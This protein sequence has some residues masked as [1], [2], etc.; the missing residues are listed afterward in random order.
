MHVGDGVDGTLTT[1]L[2]VVTTGPVG[3]H[4][5]ETGGAGGLGQ[6]VTGYRLLPGGDPRAGY[7]VFE[8]GAVFASTDYGAVTLSRELA[9]A[10]EQSATRELAGGTAQ[11]LL[12]VPVEPAPPGSTVAT[13][14]RG[15]LVRVPPAAGR[16]AVGAFTVVGD[17][18]DCYVR[19]GVTATLGLPV[20]DQQSRPD[21]G[22]RQRFEHGEICWRSDL[23][24]FAVRNP[25]AAWW[26]PAGPDGPLGYP[27]RDVVPF[28]RVYETVTVHWFRGSFERGDLY[29]ARDGESARVV[30]GEIRTR[31]RTGSAGRRASSGCRSTTRG[32]PR[33]PA[34][35]TRTSRT[36]CWSG[37]RRAT[38]M[39]APGCSARPSSA[40]RRS[41]WS[42]RATARSAATS[43]SSSARWS[44]A[45][46]PRPAPGSTSS[47]S[48]SPRTTTG[49]TPATTPSPRRSPWSSLRCCAGSTS[50]RSCSP[51]TTREIFREDEAP[52][53]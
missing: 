53:P 28:D 27:T 45:P 5:A 47:T 17:I 19:P 48:A 8:Q 51:R 4:W 31:T 15:V 6:P 42:T 38:R 9:A 43:T 34:A 16:A 50:S 21:G 39:P 13:F 30:R 12:G 25:I 1:V 32:R 46:T 41:C 11:S 37:T 3:A 24:A 20:E 2:P 40:S 7:Q 10:W 35:R 14:Q 44:S 18:Y 36:G 22:L 26:G 23:G 29:A 52:A 49:T 33:R